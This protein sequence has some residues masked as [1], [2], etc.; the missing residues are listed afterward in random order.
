MDIVLRF[1][2]MTGL[3]GQT[4]YVIIIGSLCNALGIIQSQDRVKS[5]AST[6]WW[7]KINPA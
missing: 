6:P 1:S 2:T 4:L 3:E 7:G 5:S